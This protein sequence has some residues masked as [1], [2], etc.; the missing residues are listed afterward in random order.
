MRTRCPRP[1]C[2][3]VFDISPAALGRNGDCPACSWRFTFTDLRRLARIETERLALQERDGRR[4]AQRHA[5]AAVLEDIRSLWNVGS[6][7]RTADGAGV[8][9]LYLTGI[10]GRPPRR[11]ISKTALGAEQAVPWEYCS[12]ALEAID[13]LRAGG[14]QVI[15]LENT[16]QA[17]SINQINITPPVALVIGNEVSGVSA[18]V[19]D[20]V[21]AHL[22]LPMYGAKGSLNVAVAFGI[23]A[24][25]LVDRVRKG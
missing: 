4:D 2:R 21:D 24:Y 25:A 3:H 17:Q 20:T 11:E 8:A 18:P 6:I 22:G 16:P 1:G 15:A 19:L 10:T 7:F 12:D 5:V 23:A 13:R 9:R 14:H